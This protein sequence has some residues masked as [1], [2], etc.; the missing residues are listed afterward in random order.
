MAEQQNPYN[1]QP[2]GTY[3]PPQQPQYPPP[4]GGQQQPPP[5]SGGPAPT[6]KLIDH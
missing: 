6:G 2:Q 4:Q 5:Y 1:Q 3:P